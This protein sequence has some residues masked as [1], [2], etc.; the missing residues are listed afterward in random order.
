MSAGTINAKIEAVFCQR[1]KV[2]YDF[3]DL[4]DCVREAECVVHEPQHT[5][6]N[7]WVT[8]ASQY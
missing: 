1:S 5:G 2:I 4:T 6:Y 3:C 8:G 7:N